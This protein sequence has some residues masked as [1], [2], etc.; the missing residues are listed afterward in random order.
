MPVGT[1]PYKLVGFQFGRFLRY[2]IPDLSQVDEVMQRIIPD[3]AARSTAFEDAELSMLCH[4]APSWS[5]VPRLK[6]LP[7]VDV[8]MTNPRG[9]A[10][11]GI[12]NTCCL[13]YDDVRV[14]R[15]LAHAIDLNSP[16]GAVAGRSGLQMLSPAP[17]VNALYGHDLPAHARDP[18]AARRLLD[19][20]GHPPDADGMRFGFD[21]LFPNHDVG[22]VK[23]GDILTRN[24]MDVGI[25]ADVQQLD[26]LALDQKG[27]AARR[28]DMVAETCGLGPDPDMRM[29]RLCS[30]G[31]VD[32]PGIPF[33]NTSGY[34]KPEVNAMSEQQ[35]V[36]AT[37]PARK[38][39]HDRIQSW[40]RQDLPVLPLFSCSAPSAYGS[41]RVSG[42]FQGASGHHDSLPGRGLRHRRP[43]RAR[44]PAAG[45]PDRRGVITILTCRP[46]RARPPEVPER[47]AA[48]A[49]AVRVPGRCPGDATVRRPGT[50]RA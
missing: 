32:R 6:K 34:V 48:D 21:R 28:F 5:D 14:P 11:A 30:R 41:M 47:A 1:K 31:N 13:P 42:V 2:V 8:A 33:T 4:S 15:A 22:R 46:P 40:I 16:R 50:G 38:A 35:R 10:F 17:P 36:Q 12:V 24:L 7:G 27:D 23:V 29:G 44:P 20:A 3:A 26:R 37:P 39:I 25:R 43:R 19:E 49:A 45:A 9:A 18:E